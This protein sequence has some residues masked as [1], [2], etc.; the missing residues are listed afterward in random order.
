MTHPIVLEAVADARRADL[1]RAAGRSR[2]AV[3]TREARRRRARFAAWLKG[4]LRHPTPPAGVVNAP[5]SAWAA[6]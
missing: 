1:L 5:R 4:Q 3:L 2:G 6:R